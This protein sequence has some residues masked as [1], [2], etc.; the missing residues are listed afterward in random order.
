MKF[1]LF[2]FI[3]VTLI[4]FTWIIAKK[5][6][7]L[8]WSDL[9]LPVNGILFW[10]ILALLGFG[11]QDKSALNEIPIIL[12]ISLLFSMLRVFILDN[13]FK[14]YQQNS[15]YVLFYSLAVVFLLRISMPLLVQ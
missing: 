11:E 3:Y 5:K 15:N 1:M 7:A 6:K 13:T 10:V 2:I 14:N 8:F 9:A 12:V 4:L